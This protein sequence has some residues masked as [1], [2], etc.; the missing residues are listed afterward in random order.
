MRSAV[1]KIILAL[2]VASFASSTANAGSQ[3]GHYS[4][5]LNKT[6]IVYLP[7]AASAVIIGNP[8]IAD[9][10]I[11]S[12]DTIFVIGRGYGETN[13]IVL[14]AAGQ[15]I[16]NADVQVTN[17]LSANGVRLY[18]GAVRQTYNCAPYCQPAPVLGDHGDFIDD[19][20]VESA[21]INNSVST[22]VPTNSPSRSSATGPTGAPP[23][24]Y[25]SPQY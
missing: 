14:N 23:Q 6:E 24:S 2:G 4:V 18:N 5:E 12:S 25:N 1:F 7:Q 11:H 19:N 20:T 21:P 17:P 9:V 16:M 13:L 8:Q 10:S 15:T 3:S 22:A